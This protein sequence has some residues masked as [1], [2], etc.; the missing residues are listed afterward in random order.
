MRLQV[1]PAAL[2]H[3]V[4]GQPAMTAHNGTC[5]VDDITRFKA[6]CQTAPQFNF[7]RS[8]DKTQLL[9]IRFAGRDQSELPRLVTDRSLVSH[10]AQRKYRRRKLALIQTVERVGLVL[11][12]V[13]RAMQREPITAT[14]EPRI[15]ARGDMRCANGTHLFEQ[16]S[17]LDALV[18]AQA[19]VGRAPRHV[20]RLE[21]GDDMLPESR[22]EIPGVM[23][24]AK[25]AGNAPGIA[26]GIKRTA[27]ALAV[28]LRVARQHRQGYA[29]NVEAPRHAPCRGKTGIDPSRHGDGNARI[30]R[31]QVERIGRNVSLIGRPMSL[32]LAHYQA[33]PEKHD[34]KHRLR[35]FLCPVAVAAVC[36]GLAVGLPSTQASHDAY[37]TPPSVQQQMTAPVP[38]AQRDLDGHFEATGAKGNIGDRDAVTFEGRQMGV[39]EAQMQR[40]DFGTWHLY[41]YDYSAGTTV[42]IP[43][44]TKAGQVSAGNPTV[45]ALRLPDGRQGLVATDYVFSKQANAG[46]ELIYVRALS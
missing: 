41:S 21:T 25:L 36:L 27:A 28:M 10:R 13:H 1:E 9:R 39:F 19:R 40:D 11:E 35:S 46:G 15:M 38:Q 31:N 45:T 24:D 20:L 37:P 26:H 5:S 12:S 34:P 3:G 16:H 29:H 33:M 32:H 7:E 2:P 18:A 23:A 8:V 42:E 22:L 6:P 43:L 17:E 30:A 4:E 44:A 14:T